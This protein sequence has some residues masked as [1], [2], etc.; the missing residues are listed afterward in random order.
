MKIAIDTFGCNHAKS[1]HG[2][3]VTNFIQN[4]P[5]ENLS[6]FEL[7]GF[8]LDRYSFNSGRDITFKSAKLSD[9]AKSI[10]KFHEKKIE[11]LILKN[12][13]DY[14]IFPAAENALP[15]TFK[16]Y[17][18]IA[19][20]NTIISSVLKTQP[21]KEKKLLKGLK[22]IQIIIA[23]SNFIKEDL[24]ALGISDEKIKVIHNGIDH[25][26]FYPIMN[27]DSTIVNISPFAIKRPYF[28]YGSTLSAAE[29]KHIELIKAF[30][31]FKE[32]TGLPHRLVLAGNDGEYSEKIHK[33]AFNSKYASDIFIT[34]YFPPKDFSMLYA[35]AELCIF[36]SVKE[37]VGLPILEA[38][39]CG[40]PVLCSNE[41]ALKEIGGNCPLYF[42][43]NKPDEIADKIEQ[44]ISDKK[45]R[46]KMSFEGI[47]WASEFTPEKTVQETIDLISKDFKKT[48][49]G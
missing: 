34:G 1:G 43:S 10:Q 21:K 24:L 28:I 31:I 18:G 26:T 44:C 16:K 42:N 5:E 38:M 15:L 17:K 40:I 36:P 22:N 9:D 11:K 14:V 48:L 19:I 30:E 29:K 46:K 12:N 35:G 45:L 13:Y 27:I 20:V 47:V 23:A 25:K 8:E 6:C 39:A 41:G 7:L 3:Y 32:K 4:I 33:V 49:N 2:S 37:G